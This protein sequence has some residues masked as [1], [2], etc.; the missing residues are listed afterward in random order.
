MAHVKDKDDLLLYFEWLCNKAVNS[1]PDH[2]VTTKKYTEVLKKLF[3]VEFTWYTGPSSISHDSNRAADG[4]NLRD[5]FLMDQAFG[6]HASEYPGYQWRNYILDDIYNY[7]DGKGSILEMMVALA[8][9]ME[10]QIMQNDHYDNRT[11]QWFFVMMDTSGLSDYDD[12][13]YDLYEVE[14][15][16]SVLLDR[17]YDYDGTHG[18]FYIRNPT[19][20]LRFT[21]IWYQAMWWIT[22]RE[23]DEGNL[24]N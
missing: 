5:K 12:E 20:D 11:S 8:S 23:R 1:D 17:L 22:Q 7:L 15:I 13:N 21:E 14:S 4:L 18:F 9:R 3:S 10:S 16:I 2:P 6:E 24:K 19:H